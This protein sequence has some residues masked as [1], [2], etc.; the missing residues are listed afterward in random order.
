ME[1]QFQKTLL[2]CLHT[3]LRSQESQEQTQEVRISDGMP[4]IGSI[5]GTWGQVILRAK[6]W[7][8][9][10]LTVS[11]GTM[12]WVQYLPE[13]GGLPQMMETWI[14]FQMRF[15]IPETSH[16]G[17]MLAQ[18]LLKSV[19]ARST[20]ARKFMLRTNISCLLQAL[21][22]TQWEL[23]QPSE[24]PEDVQLH[25]VSYPILLPSEAGEKAFSLE[26]TFPLHTPAPQRILSS[27]LQVQIS[28]Y[29]L[30]GDKLIFRGIGLLRILWENQDG[31]QNTMDYDLPFSQYTELDQTYDESAQAILWPAVTALETE[32][33]D[34]GLHVRTGL[35]V[36]YVIRHRPMI[37]VVDDAYSPKRHVELHTQQL[38]LPGILESKSQV[39]HCQSSSVVDA[40]SAVDVQ[41]LPQPISCQNGSLEIPVT[42]HT[43]CR[44]LEGN[45]R[46]FTQKCVETLSIPMAEN[47]SLE[48]IA[49]STGR[50]QANIL[51]GNLQNQGDLELQTDAV[52]DAN[53]PM[54]TGLT[55]GE[56]QP[57]DPHRPSIILRR[58]GEHT[59]W[60]I[61]KESG[62]TVEDIRRVNRL[63][64]EPNA[65]QMLLI[66]IQ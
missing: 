3:L 9:D 15:P 44:D 54:V 60:Q 4:D 23:Y 2:P 39:L 12:V 34:S 19:D 18:C 51:S 40:T 1:L 49:W 21:A 14:P 55:I 50:T 59:L 48:A 10:T 45:Y 58:A 5:L 38:Q 65:D 61:A 28:E 13:E 31:S 36:Q 24:V 47:V 63:Q 64:A 33:Q 66:P 57:A 37:Q 20:S 41:M 17:V 11:G 27:S 46:S 30:L 43:L 42:F 6:E 8:S 22:R 35:V 52:M 7:Q 25:K 29:R 26:E 56:V 32:L 53:I 62:A 16:D